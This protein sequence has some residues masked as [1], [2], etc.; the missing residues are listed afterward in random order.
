MKD[1]RDFLVPEHLE[2]IFRVCER[3]DDFASEFRVLRRQ[4]HDHAAADPVVWSYFKMDEF[5]RWINDM[6]WM[7]RM[8]Q[9]FVV[10]PTCRG[11]GG[12]ECPTCGGR[13]WLTKP[14]VKQAQ[15][16]GRWPQE[17][18]SDK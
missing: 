4:V 18:T 7:F 11:I 10:C 12:P 15:R 6:I 5:D 1:S 16:Y 8:A 14:G 3:M 17:T 2:H 13:Q 9:P